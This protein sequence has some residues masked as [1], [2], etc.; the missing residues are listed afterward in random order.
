[1]LNGPAFFRAAPLQCY[2]KHA[3]ALHS[4]QSFKTWVKKAWAMHCK[5]CTLDAGIIH[6]MP[7]E[8]A[9]INS[10]KESEVKWK[11]LSRV[12]LFVTPWTIQSMEFSRPEY[13]SG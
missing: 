9:V 13:W 5:V 10:E 1:M 7:M 3:T 4:P 6:T 8:K 11:L 2:G 12:Q